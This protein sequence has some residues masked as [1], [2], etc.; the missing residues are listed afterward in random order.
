MASLGAKTILAE[1][2]IR[3]NHYASVMHEIKRI[4]ELLL[5]E[6]GCQVTTS[7]LGEA[8]QVNGRIAGIIDFGDLEEVRVNHLTYIFY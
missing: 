2:N 3:S 4:L 6:G 5:E 8:P 7:T 1:L